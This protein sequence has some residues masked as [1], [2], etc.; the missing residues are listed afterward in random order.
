[1]T[2]SPS[3]NMAKFFPKRP[4]SMKSMGKSSLIGASK[5]V[6]TVTIT[7]VPNTQKISYTNSP[8]R[9]MQPIGKL[10]D[11]RKIKDS[12]KFSNRV[13][14]NRGQA[15]FPA[16]KAIVKRIIIW[17]LHSISGLFTQP[18]SIANI[19]Q[20]KRNIVLHYEGQSGRK[21]QPCG[22]PQGLLNTNNLFVRI[23]AFE[24]RHENMRN[25]IHD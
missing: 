25:F 5:E 11:F 17:C 22:S 15:R 18:S 3:P 21:K 10:K 12:I 20:Q 9:R 4:L 19:T 24:Q 8:P 7:S 2:I 1:M 14:Q 23:F 16:T 13:P 6:A